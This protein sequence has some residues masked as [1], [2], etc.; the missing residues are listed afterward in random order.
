MT[1]AP[2]A[3]AFLADLE[4][5]RS[6]E[7]RAKYGRYFKTGPGDY[8]EGDTFIGVRM[9]TVFALARAADR[10]PLE[11]IETLLESPIHE[12]RAGALRIMAEQA[13]ARRTT[14]DQRREL[15][16]LYLRRIDRIDNWDLVDLAAWDV[17]GRYLLDKPRDVLVEL[18]GSDDLWARRTAV[19][20]T[21]AFIRAGE[22]ADAFHIAAILVDDPQDLIQKAVGGILRA[23][24]DA[25]RPG[26]EAFLASHAAT[27]PRTSLRYATEHL[28]ADDRA[29][30]LAMRAGR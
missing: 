25:D 2:T 4:A 3:A 6:D 12:A 14:D 18:A 28:E 1:E 17:V 24:G 19:L 8:A 7:E 30:Y 15:Y 29:R 13:K 10:M 21:L 9:G 23:A 26:L 27:M 5:D 16:D 20:A 22:T 11:E